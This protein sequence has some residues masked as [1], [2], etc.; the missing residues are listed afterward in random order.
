[1]AK[2]DTIEESSLAS[3]RDTDIQVFNKFGGMK[4]AAMLML[5][6][7]EQHARILSERMAIDEMKAITQEMTDLGRVQGADVDLLLRE[8]TSMMGAGF[9]VVGSYET[10][11]QLLSNILDEDKV[12]LIM[13]SIGEHPGGNVWE[14]LSKVDDNVLVNFL[15]NEYPQTIAVVLS[16][17][18]TDQ[19]ARVM[20]QLPSEV[21][22]EAMMRML[23][24]ELVQDE[25]MTD[26]EN[27]LR[28]EFMTNATGKAA[29]DQHEVMAEIFN[30]FDRTTETSFLDMLDER[31]KES[32]ELIR[33]LM[34]TFDDLAKLDAQAVQL[35][36]RNVDNSRLG[37]A[38]KGAKD[39]LKELF[40]ANMSE[41][42]AKIL[43][44]DM[45]NMG[46]VRVKEVEEA[47]SEIVISAKALIDNGE[48][49]LATDNDEDMIS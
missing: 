39:E 45:E 24:L 22:I 26:V 25:V 7:G 37:L 49:T 23:R 17:I 38:L 47:Q 20:S 14:K 31:N 33:A 19:A 35:L 36:L 16:K 40:F 9:G 32:A 18:R 30:Y 4:K 21:A 44:E 11:K 12:S 2:I 3:L 42:A 15:K 13:K 27:L 34:F 43:R 1:M 28:V 5:V 48:I 41:R 10:A 8:F 6:I 29:R 46:P